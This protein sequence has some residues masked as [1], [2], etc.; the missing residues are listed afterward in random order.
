M[1]DFVVVG[2][3]IVGL[4]TAGAL[5]QRRPDAR[6]VVLDKADDVAT[7]QTGHNSGVIHAGL[8]YPPGSLK[9]RLCRVGERATKQFCDEH[10]IPYREIGKLVV[11][12]DGVEVERMHALAARAAQN[13]IDLEQVDAGELR[14]REPHVRGLAALFSP[15]SAIVDFR[16][17]ATA[18]A[19]EVVA[20]GG[21]VV[22]RSE[23]TG[24]E[25]RP[26]GVR[27]TSSTG[28]YS[29]RMLVACAGLQADRVARMAGLDTDFRIVPFRG[30]YHQ[31]PESRR[32]MVR[33]LIYPVP[34]PA[35]P[36]LGVHLSPMIDGRVTV[37][38]N[39]VLGLSREDHRRGAVR[40]R[41]VASY[42]TFPGMWRFARRNARTGVAE[43]RD[44]LS[45]RG[46]LRL[47]NR[48][49]PELGLEDLLPHPAGIRA[50]AIARDGTPVEDFLVERSGRQ[51]HVCNAPSPAAT[52]AL[53]IGAM[54]ADRA[55]ME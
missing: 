43:I 33:H 45:R 32:D 35:L 25:E 14:E 46:Y 48:Y 44:S 22:L 52:S 36:F 3:G 6:V 55:L 31:L 23:V 12:T 18:L 29:A 2:A 51:L 20:H 27:I 38:P 34:D 54:I 19:E 41:D 21:R 13:G 24:I 26:D 47:V 40:L 15:R 28:G 5:Q 10:G 11:A 39:A 16:R 17:V 30:E 9:A 42:A 49:C 1:E 4:A 7:A 53:P 50:Q 37:G 8:Y